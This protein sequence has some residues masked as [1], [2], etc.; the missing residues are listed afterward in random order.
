MIIRSKYGIPPPTNQTVD[1]HVTWRA[2]PVDI[3]Q[4][5]FK[6]WGGI[7][8]LPIILGDKLCDSQEL[9]VVY[10]YDIPKGAKR[11]SSTFSI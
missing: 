4:L 10:E 9:W 2:Q 3:I 5:L 1:Q 7:P 6:L 8:R 11:A